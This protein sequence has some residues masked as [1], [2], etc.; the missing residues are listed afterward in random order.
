MDQT[1]VGPTVSGYSKTEFALGF[2]NVWFQRPR[3]IENFIAATIARKEGFEGRM[4]Q[5]KRD[6]RQQMKMDANI[7]GQGN[8]ER[9]NGFA[10]QRP[11]FDGRIEEAQAD[12]RGR[13]FQNGRISY[14]R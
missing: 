3:R 12:H 8:E 4:A 5:G 9:M 13:D 10:I 1:A 7:G 2:C 11:K 6:S 14:V